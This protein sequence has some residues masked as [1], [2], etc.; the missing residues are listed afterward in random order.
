[1]SNIV[2]N[3]SVLQKLVKLRK[4]L[5]NRSTDE[6]LGKEQLQTDLSEF[7]KPLIT[8]Q[9]DTGKSQIKA[10]D[11]LTGKTGELNEQNKLKFDKILNELKKQ[12]LIIPLIKSLNNHPNVVS[13]IKGTEEDI[14]TLTGAERKVLK[15]LKHID[16][17]ILNVLIDYYTLK[18][19]LP[20]LEEKQ[21]IGEPEEEL[22][23][24]SVEVPPAYQS[25]GFQNEYLKGENKNFDT[26]LKRVKGR[27]TEDA[28]GI[29][30]DEYSGEFVIGNDKIYFDNKNNIKIG[31]KIYKY[32]AGLEQL[33]TILTPDVSNIDVITADDLRIYLQ[34]LYNSDVEGSKEENMM[35][36]HYI[37]KKH[38]DVLERLDSNTLKQLIANYGVKI[39]KGLTKSIIL[40]SDP[41]EL[42]KRLDIS[43]RSYMAGN[44]SL[45][46]EI[47]EI[48]TQ[49]YR[50]KQ[51]NRKQLSVLLKSL[52][53]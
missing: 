49:L 7:Y 2:E 45:Y 20:E 18:D 25:G 50:M 13:I 52:V 23:R 16:D 29:T 26:L 31:D 5:Y 1:M 36:H 34:I 44:K 6:K 17:R 40:P 27:K 10:I 21:L 9:Q 3:K 30:Y 15:E 43:I 53:N 47:N 39:G 19:E 51:I 11:R 28:I 35:K 33:L 24:P 41:N 8:T 14:S 46:N 4:K 22:N 32:T 42:R 38:A 37:Y 12:P 48:A